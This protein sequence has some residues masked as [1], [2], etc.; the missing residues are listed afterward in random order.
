MDQKWRIAV[1]KIYDLSGLG[2]NSALI[3]I[4]TM[5]FLVIGYLIDYIVRSPSDVSKTH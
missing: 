4:I 5:L 1:R 3:R 2:I